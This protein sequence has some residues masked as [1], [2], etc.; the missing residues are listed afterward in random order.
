MIPFELYSISPDINEFGEI[1]RIPNYLTPNELQHILSVRDNHPYVIEG[2]DIPVHAFP[3]LKIPLH[4][5]Y[6]SE[7]SQWLFDNWSEVVLPLTKIESLRYHG[8]I[9]PN[10]PIW[11]DESIRG[12]APNS[13][14]Y[15]PHTDMGSHK[16][17]TILVPLDDVGD[18]TIFNGSSRSR[19]WCHEWALN[20]AYM[21]RP[22]ERSY[23]S[24]QNT[25]D[26]N[27]WILNINICGTTVEGGESNTTL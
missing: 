13:K 23:H 4:G 6:A 11:I 10:P 3:S 20:D 17:L 7:K 1:Y 19:V 8:D 27:R 2:E 14:L 9:H 26:S 16:L 21:F 5:G 25:R 24:Y 18:S 22:S 12:S 15:P